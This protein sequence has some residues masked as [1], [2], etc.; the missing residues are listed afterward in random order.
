MKKILFIGSGSMGQSLIKGM[1]VGHYSKEWEIHVISPHVLDKKDSLG[2]PSVSLHASSDELI[3]LNPDV[4][5]FAVKPQI[6]P[7]LLPFYS[8]IL[9]DKTICLSI[10]A[11]VSLSTL[12]KGLPQARWVRAMPNLGA[13]VGRGVTGLFTD[14]TLD[15][16][17]VDEVEGIFK[18]VG[19]AFWTVSEDA[20]DGVTAISGSGPAYF[21]R[22]V[23]ALEKAALDLG[24]SPDEARQL[25]QETFLGAAALLSTG[26]S[27]ESWRKKVTSPGGTTQA[28]LEVLGGEGGI[29]DLFKRTVSAAYQRAKELSS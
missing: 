25:S 4:V 14:E 22:A 28:A 15:R 8:K 5:V 3:D 19:W 10:A 16:R 27:A 20:I 23:E 29:D 13:T 21:F 26:A 24:F 9:Q 6:L 11:G 17:T 18:G 7:S 12:R 2:L 1:L